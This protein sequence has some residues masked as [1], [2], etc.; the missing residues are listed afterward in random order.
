MTTLISDDIVPPPH[1]YQCQSDGVIIS[2][3]ISLSQACV[4]GVSCAYSSGVTTSIVGRQAKYKQEVTSA[5]CQY[6]MRDTQSAVCLQ[7]QCEERRMPR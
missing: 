4:S 2:A 1:T 7:K 3:F 5:V 6:F